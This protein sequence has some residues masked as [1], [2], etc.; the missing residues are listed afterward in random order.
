L[1][2]PDY[3]PLIEIMKKTGPLCATSANHSGEKAAAGL[4]EI[5]EE[6]K[7]ACDLVMN[8]PGRPSGK[9]SKVID[10]TEGETKV[11]RE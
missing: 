6:I 11:V 3:K 7:S 4:D 5:P 1:R 8:L 10:L 9:P 2:I